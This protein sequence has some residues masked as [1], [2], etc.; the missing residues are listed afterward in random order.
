MRTNDKVVKE[1][2]EIQRTPIIEACLKVQWTKKLKAD[3]NIPKFETKVIAKACSRAEGNLCGA[4]AFPDKKWRGGI[5]NLATHLYKDP[6]KQ[7][8][9]Q[10]FIT[11]TTMTFKEFEKKKEFLNP[12]KQSKRGN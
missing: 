1:L 5:C 8:E 9:V 6:P 4:C 12:I 10:T 2:Y 11:P 7:G 3:G